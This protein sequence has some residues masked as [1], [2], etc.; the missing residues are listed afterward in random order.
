MRI[1]FIIAA[2]TLCFFTVCNNASP[3]TYQASA[4]STVFA[5]NPTALNSPSRKIAK[6]ADVKCRVT[7]IISTVSA[8]EQFVNNVS[9]LVSVSEMEN[10]PLKK[11]VLRY[12]HDSLKEVNEYEP[13]ATLQL[14]IPH[15]YLDTFLQALPSMVDFIEY[16]NIRQDDKTLAYLANA[17]KNKAVVEA[18]KPASIKTSKNIHNTDTASSQ[19]AVVNRQIDNLQILDDVNYAKLSIELTQPKQLYTTVIPDTEY[20]ASE[21]FMKRLGNNFMKGWEM[22]GNIFVAV[23]AIWPLVFLATIIFLAYGIRRRKRIIV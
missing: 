1:S 11:T 13:I 20:A 22:L 7:N 12:T 6:Q 8:M 2:I 14:R 19:L 9:G 21:P 17:L 3:E 23:M 4:D 15:I 18:A 5:D 10:K 16:R